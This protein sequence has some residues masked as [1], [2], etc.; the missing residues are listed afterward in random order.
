MIPREVYRSSHICASIFD[1]DCIVHRTS[2]SVSCSPGKLCLQEFFSDLVLLRTCSDSPIRV[3]ALDG[4]ELSRLM[5]L[6]SLGSRENVF[7][8]VN[9]AE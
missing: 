7:L 2:K 8:L 4:L 1:I 5:V 6:R 3:R 9:V